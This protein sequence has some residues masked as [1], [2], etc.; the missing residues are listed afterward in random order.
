M[1]QFFK[2]AEANKFMYMEALFWKSKRDAFEIENGY[3]SYT[4]KYV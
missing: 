1:R 3:G 2:V 4:E